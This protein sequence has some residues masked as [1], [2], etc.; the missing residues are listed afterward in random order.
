MRIQLAV[1]VAILLS[2]ACGSA[3]SPTNPETAREGDESRSVADF[4]FESPLAD[5]LGRDIGA[6]EF[7]EATLRQEQLEFERA[8]AE[9][10]AE[11]GFEYT[12]RDPAQTIFVTSSE[13]EFER[14]STAWT[15]KYGFGITTRWFP[16][17]MVGDLVGRADAGFTQP[18]VDFVDPN[19]EYVEGLS[20]GE[21]D[22]YYEALQ[23]PSPEFGPEGPDEDFVFEPQGCQSEAFR[24]GTERDSNVQRFNQAFGDDVS[25]LYERVEADSRMVAFQT[26]VSACVAEAGMEW[27]GSD[28]LYGRFQSRMLEL[29]PD[30][31][32][33]QAIFEAAGLDPETM[34][35]R[36]LDAFVADMKQLTPEKL[37][38]LAELQA[39]EIALA[40]RVD[41]CGGS[42]LQ[43]QVI[44]NQ[45]QVEY[46]QEFLNQNADALAEFA[47]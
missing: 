2:A 27:T 35:E 33:E 40:K 17:S 3:S 20:E 1:L 38:I 11:K 32:S 8:T 46:E 29:Q 12:S 45:I 9:C 26:E 15:N 28:D 5:F 36:E 44:R 13:D 41:A 7:D 10:M 4:E 39:E 22:A 19:Q 42:Q 47:G 37:S 14:G 16:Q 23:G 25:A 43:E 34:S 18:D 24:N 31:S 30:A 6:F 21:R